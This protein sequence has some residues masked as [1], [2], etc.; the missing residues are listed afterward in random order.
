MYHRWATNPTSRTSSATV[1]AGK[2]LERRGEWLETV[3]ASRRS[4]GS[5]S[6]AVGEEQ[7]PGDHDRDAALHSAGIDLGRV[8]HVLRA[9]LMQ[10]SLLIEEPHREPG[11]SRNGKQERACESESRNESRH[12]LI[13]PHGESLH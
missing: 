12:A 9:P 11:S 6:A 8:V 10:R 13:L 5:A 7:Q 4:R 1:T 3:H 2:I